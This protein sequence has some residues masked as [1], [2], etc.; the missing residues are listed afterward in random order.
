MIKAASVKAASTKAPARTPSVTPEFAM[1]GWIVE[2]DLAGAGEPPDRRFFA[3]GLATADEAV[4]RVLCFPGLTRE[5]P[6]RALRPLTPEEIARLRLRT[7]AV[8]SYGQLMK[9]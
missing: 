9:R 7:A 6:R 3:V 8:R 4:E 1:A 2:A 5:D